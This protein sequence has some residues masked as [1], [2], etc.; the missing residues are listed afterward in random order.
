MH[1][2]THTATNI[3]TTTYAISTTTTTTPSPTTP[4]I[5]QE[6][7]LHITT[8]P[9]KHYN[10]PTAN[11]NHNL[12]WILLL[13]GIYMN[14][15]STTGRHTYSPTTQP[16]LHNH[17]S[18]HTHTHTTDHTTTTTNCI[19]L[20]PRG[21]HGGHTKRTLT[22]GEL[23]GDA[24]YELGQEI[25]PRTSQE[26]REYPRDTICSALVHIHHTHTNTNNS[27]TA[28]ATIDNTPITIHCNDYPNIPL[29][30]NGPHKA[31]R[32]A[33]TSEPG[34]THIT[35]HTTDGLSGLW[36]HLTTPPPTQTITAAELYSGIGGHHHAGKQ[37]DW[38]FSLAIDTSETANEIYRRNHHLTPHNTPV[39]SISAL[40]LL[41][42]TRPDIL[43]A[44][45]RCQ[46]W[47]HAGMQQGIRDTRGQDALHIA[48]LA[49]IVN[50][51]GLQLE[52]VKGFSEAE[53][54]RIAE[55]LL[56]LFRTI[57]Y[58]SSA[59]TL[60]LATIR[61][62]SRGRWLANMIRNDWWKD[63]TEA[64]FAVNNYLYDNRILTPKFRNTEVFQ[65]LGEMGLPLRSLSLQEVDQL[66]LTPSELG[67]FLDPTFCPEGFKRV[68]DY[69]SKMPCPLHSWGS[70]L[71]ACICGCR[72]NPFSYSNLIKNGILAPI[73]ERTHPTTG[74]R[75]L[76]HP[77][78]EECSLP[79][80]F[81]EET[82]WP[83][84][85]RLALALIG[86]AIAPHHA[87]AA[88]A[89]FNDIIN[90]INDHPT[91]DNNKR[92]KT[93]QHEQPRQQHQNTRTTNT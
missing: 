66:S 75:F 1:I 26:I 16:H 84:S 71:S 34:A 68:I 25:L 53:G 54:G 47:S 21:K 3:C 41:L 44:G 15:A 62:I 78:V 17:H 90:Y 45:F 14:N 57:G 2:T 7:P 89:S 72:A 46:P 13:T 10:N 81:D 67:P 6:T 69:D 49:S 48:E 83:H 43:T 50:P 87:I 82:T 61:P 88:M 18:L 8:P 55:H 19:R 36:P 4:P 80:G 74:A 5:P 20:L 24:C 65:R 79:M 60:D 42:E 85:H 86:N 64:R 93:Q 38:R 91:P 23:F 32:I 77:T 30:S 28:H 58:Y 76:S 27:W 33:L 29:P 31:H 92:R 56:R 63:Y 40:R 35:G 11:Y 22:Q 39:H 51:A 73:I 52:C 37:L 9:P 12:L 70:T 59:T